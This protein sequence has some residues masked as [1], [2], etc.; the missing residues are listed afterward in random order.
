MRPAV[1]LDDRREWHRLPISVPFFVRGK[2]ANGDDFL[3]FATALNL[4]AGGA[5]VATKRYLEPGTVLSLEI[6]VV[7][8]S[9][10]QLPRSV[11]LLEATVLRC[12]PSR[13]YHLLGLRF[14]EPLVTDEAVVERAEASRAI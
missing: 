5:L 6:P 9:K 14:T 2:K 3:E 10:A 4:S 1:A 7:L 11:S 13:Q 8:A 12:S